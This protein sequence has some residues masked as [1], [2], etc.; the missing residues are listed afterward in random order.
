MLHLRTADLVGGNSSTNGKNPKQRLAPGLGK[1]ATTLDQ[2]G[3]HFEHSGVKPED[4]GH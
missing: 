4:I 1:V 3:K 2:Y